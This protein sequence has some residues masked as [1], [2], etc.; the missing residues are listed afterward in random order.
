MTQRKWL[1]DVVGVNWSQVTSCDDL[2]PGLGTS[3]FS[4][5]YETQLQLFLAFLREVLRAMSEET[6]LEGHSAEVPSQ[7]ALLNLVVVLP[8]L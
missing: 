1:G 8:S 4:S 3:K 6:E 2:L 7:T 5:E